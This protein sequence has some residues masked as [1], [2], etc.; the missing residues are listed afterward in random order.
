[1]SSFFLGLDLGQAQ[2]P[3]AL[4]A[5]ERIETL[6][7]TNARY[8]VRHLE[9]A[10]LGMPYTG[11]VSRISVLLGRDPLCG[12][13]R[14]VVD[15]TGVGAPVVDLLVQ[16]RMSPVAVTITAGETVSRDGAAYR[17][18]KRD[19]VGT[20]QVLLQSGRLKIADAIPEARLLVKEMLAFRVKIT[21][22]AHDTYGAWREGAHDDLVLA[23]ALACWYGEHYAPPACARVLPS[24]GQQYGGRSWVDRSI[25]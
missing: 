17:V 20:M 13:T 2:D 3:T 5:V 6:S 11:I 7:G 22:S 16:A 15:A 14:L 24:L 12:R 10:P 23:V 9:R 25:F 4:V 8:H 1:M 19:L 21:T 18:P